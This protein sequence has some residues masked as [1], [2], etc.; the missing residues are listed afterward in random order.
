[1][2]MKSQIHIDGLK[3]LQVKIQKIGLK[4]RMN[5]HRNLLVIINFKNPL[6]KI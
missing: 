1:M 2:A 4:D 5:L 3:I 6:I